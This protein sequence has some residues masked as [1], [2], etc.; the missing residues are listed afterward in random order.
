VSLGFKKF[1][2]FGEANDVVK[3]FTDQELQE[4]D[5]VE[6]VDGSC[7]I[8]SIFK[9]EPIIRTR[10]NFDA[11]EHENTRDEL[12]ILKQRY[13][14]AFYNDDL[15]SEEFTYIYEWTTRAN[16]IIVDYGAEP[17]IR[18]IGLVAHDTYSLV[19]QKDLVGI[20]ADIEVKS[21]A[22]IKL[23]SLSNIQ[24][25]LE[26]MTMA[27]GYCVY[28]NH[29]QDIKKVKCSWYLDRH[30]HKFSCNLNNL[31]ELYIEYNLP[32]KQ[33]FIDK[34]RSFID[35]ECIPEVNDLVDQIAIARRKVE[36]HKNSMLGFI[37]N[38]PIDQERKVTAGMIID[39]YQDTGL[40]PYVFS[41]LDRG[42][43]QPLQI[44]KLILSLI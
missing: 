24:H 34:L 18:L 12:S 44:K 16:R 2:N 1:F 19:S 37:N 39:N 40:A 41:L 7:L 15:A 30:K 38:I 4:A 33:E 28:Y 27:E 22:R 23:D 32:S 26:A 35:F 17:D 42:E 9:G 8:V 14:K 31:L 5:I 3:D 6:K 25:N 43:L 13:P 29:G 11:K 10:G 20:A 21:P 36:I